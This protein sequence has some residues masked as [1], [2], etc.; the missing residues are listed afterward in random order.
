MDVK[1]WTFLI[2]GLSFA[3][4]IAIA[5][6][7]RATSTGEFYVAGKGVPSLANGMAPPPTG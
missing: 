3:L 4:Y 7:S 5:I 1:T 2:V 6:R